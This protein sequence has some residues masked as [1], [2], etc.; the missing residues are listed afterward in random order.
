MRIDPE[1]KSWRV[2]ACVLLLLIASVG[3]AQSYPVKQIRILIGF[4]PGG[5]ADVVARGLS[6]R[7][8]DGLGQQIIIDNR[9]GANGLIA[10]ELAA[11]APA[12]GYTL[13]TLGTSDAIVPALRAKLPYQLQRDLAPVSMV[14]FGPSVVAVHPSL[15]VRNAKEL[16]ALAKAR[17]G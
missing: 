6:P 10:A 12:D 17:P 14:A 7:L 8:V 15:P 9:P 2:A 5:G 13:L 3:W 1:K 4:S 16:I 11:K